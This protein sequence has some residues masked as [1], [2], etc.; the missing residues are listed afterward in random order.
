[1]FTT[2]DGV[3]ALTTNPISNFTMNSAL[4][5]GY[6]TDDG[7]AAITARGVCWSTLANPT[8]ADNKTEDGTGTGS[9]SSSLN[10]LTPDTT[11]YL[12]SYATNAAGTVYGDEQTFTTRDG[13]VS[14]T[15]N[16]ISN[17][18]MNSA[19]IV[20]YITD[21]GGAA[22]TARGVC[23]STLANP[24]I[25][26]NKT[27]DGTGTGSFSSSLNGLTSD[28]T[29]YLRSYATN[30]TGTYY[31]DEQSFTTFYSVSDDF[32]GTGNL[33]WNDDDTTTEVVSNP[34]SGAGNT[35]AKILKYTDAGGQFANVAFNLSGDDTVKFDLTTKNVFTVNVYVPTPTEAVTEPKQLALKLQD[36]SASA[37]WE[38][39]EEVIQPYVYDQ[40]Q[41]LTFDF[42]AFSEETKFSRIVVQFNGEG[43]FESCEGYI[44]D[45]LLQ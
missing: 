10:G 38:G 26:D 35:S 25:A 37:P 24:T 40:W 7:G 13:V 27:E 32:E 20:G 36:G 39:Q 17:I 41:T 34:F 29:Y 28:T 31:G 11:Y 30:A 5:V 14:L 45:V 43:N 6:I 42:S 44:D 19:I 18:S 21:D 4:I 23:W 9:F 16:S 33:F 1:V 15:T 22:I 12:R 8:I 3:V 2:R